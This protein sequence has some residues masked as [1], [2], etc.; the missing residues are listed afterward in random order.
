[1]RLGSKRSSYSTFNGSV[2]LVLS[3]VCTAARLA[4]LYLFCYLS[5]CFYS[6]PVSAM[7]SDRLSRPS[8][9]ETATL[10][11]VNSSATW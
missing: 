4:Y 9:V 3:L 11:V 2:T 7:T 5:C 8:A 1:M 10:A 6:N